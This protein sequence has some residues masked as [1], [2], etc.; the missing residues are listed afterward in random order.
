MGCVNVPTDGRWTSAPP[1]PRATPGVVHVWRADLAAT[2]DGL[3]DLLCDE[4]RAR[5]ER[6]VSERDRVLWAR[7]RAVLRALLGRYLVSDPRELRFA[8]GAHGKPML[9]THRPDAVDLQFNLSHSGE[10]ALY[11]V[12]AGREVGVDIERARERYTAE[13][14]RAWVTH[15]A[16]VKCRG[17][18]LATPLGRFPAA[19]VWTAALDVGPQAA[20]AVATEGGPC[21][22]R[23]WEWRGRGPRPGS[24]A[25][26]LNRGPGTR[27]R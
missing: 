6:I 3:V 19:D 5:M 9:E 7:A 22:L 4:E 18:G 27:C 10:L 12:T 21:E 8:L 26:A 17:A 2:A 13:F 15:E 16:A 11:A 1:S 24:A 25:E 20:A 23:C 14:L